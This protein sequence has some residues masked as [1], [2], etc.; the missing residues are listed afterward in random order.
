MK[1]IFLSLLSATTLIAC[2]LEPNQAIDKPKIRKIR[3]ENTGNVQ[4]A[5]KNKTTEYTTT[6]FNIFQGEYLR[7]TPESFLQ[8]QRDRGSQ[9]LIATNTWNGCDFFRKCWNKNS[10]TFTYEF[11]PPIMSEIKSPILNVPHLLQNIF[12]RFQFKSGRTAICAASSLLY[13]K[14]NTEALLLMENSS[15]CSLYENDTDEIYD[16]AIMNKLDL[17]EMTYTSGTFLRSDDGNQS[18]YAESRYNP[19]TILTVN[20]G[21][22]KK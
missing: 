10:E 1:K 17:G 18:N 9:T 3:Q 16:V 15:E 19:E 21:I 13:E 7:L 12:L 22:G 2:S 11:S 6:G 8:E 4:L 5:L 14:N 20:I